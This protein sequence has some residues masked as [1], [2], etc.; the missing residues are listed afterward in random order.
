M[1]LKRARPDIIVDVRVGAAL[2]SLPKLQAEGLAPF[3]L[4]FIDADKK[5]NPEYFQWA[6]QLSTS[7]SIIIIDN[8]V[9]EGAVLD[10]T[11]RNEDIRGTRQVIE[12]IGKEPRVSA[13]ALQTVGSKG[14][15]GFVIAVVN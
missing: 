4:V 10:E 8:V 6:L 12:M 1:N 9:R 14:Y 5:N 3:E 13:T 15:D 11:T 7:G 2:E